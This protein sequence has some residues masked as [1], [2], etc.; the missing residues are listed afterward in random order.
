MNRVVLMFVVFVSLGVAA[1]VHAQ[2]PTLDGY[3]GAGGVI[4]EGTPD[5]GGVLGV[6]E[7]GGPSAGTPFE[8]APAGTTEAG[9]P[10]GSVLGV[11]ESGGP[12]GTSDAGGPGAGGPGASVPGATASPRAVEGTLPFTGLDVLLLAS[13]GLLLVGMGLGMRRFAHVAARTGL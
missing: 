7:T 6:T 3:G 1:P 4:D 12:A 8:G 10:A 13:G 2:G 9:G 11:T 5:E